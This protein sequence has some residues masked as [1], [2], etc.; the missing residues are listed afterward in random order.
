MFVRK[1]RSFTRGLLIAALASVTLAC[2]SSPT[3]SPTATSTATT[4]AQGRD[5]TATE[6][7]LDVLQRMS[8]FLAEQPRLAFEA[9]IAFE[10]LQ[11]ND[12]LIEFGTTRRV[13]VRRPDRAFVGARTR[14]GERRFFYFDGQ[15]AAFALPGQMVYATEA[16]AGSIDDAI[17]HLA[18]LGIPMP[19]SE[20]ISSDLFAGI[21][22]EI[23]SAS[24]VGREIVGETI[25]DHV[26]YRTAAIDFELWVGSEGAPLPHRIVIR[27]RNEPGSPGFRASL[28]AWDL[29]PPTPN[30]R[31][32][33]APPASAQRVPFDELAN[34]IIGQPEETP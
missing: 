19:L 32:D 7:A 28:G 21:G 23:D 33:F 18:S 2:A 9:E 4:D 27:Y 12:E 15:Q 20:L 26:A 3:A 16:V 31:F 11:S 5:A 25:C 10:V 17:D 14:E 34:R 6:E 24:V 29:D 22:P 13:V 8:A 1:F 30:G